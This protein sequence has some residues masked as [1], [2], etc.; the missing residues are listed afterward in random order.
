ME[1]ILDSA[2]ILERLDGDTELLGELVGLFL[3]ECPR[4]FEDIRS[5]VGANDS[6]RLL[7]AAHTLKGSVSN[8]CAP[9]A[10]ETAQALEAA[11][12]AGDLARAPELTAQLEHILGQLTAE[13]SQLIQ[14]APVA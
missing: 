4:L 8:F 13:L 12:R 3:E 10:V 11:G 7:R 14:A 1:P 2:A 9:R 5:A 6:Q